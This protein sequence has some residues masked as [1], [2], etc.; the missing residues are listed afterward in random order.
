MSNSYGIF[1]LASSPSGYCSMMLR[2]RTGILS[3]GLAFLKKSWAT[4]STQKFGLS[5]SLRTEA[6]L[7][8]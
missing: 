3:Y 4:G 8:E 6:R 7:L 5:I 2:I 1:I